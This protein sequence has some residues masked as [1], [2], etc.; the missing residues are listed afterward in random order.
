MSNVEVTQKVLRKGN[1]QV[2]ETV[3]FRMLPM[4]KHH[5]PRFV[6]LTGVGVS[7]KKCRSS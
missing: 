1:K 2:D 6:M 4:A 5:L 7:W 3:N